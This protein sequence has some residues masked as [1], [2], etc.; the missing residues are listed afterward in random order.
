MPRRALIMSFPVAGLATALYVGCD[1]KGDGDESGATDGAS[2][3]DVDGDGD[4]DGV[5]DDDDDDTTTF[6][7]TDLDGGTDGGTA[8]SAW[9]Y[10][11]VEDI[12][13]APSGERPGGD[14]DSVQLY[15]GTEDLYATAAR[16]TPGTGQSPDHADCDALVGPKDLGNLTSG[17]GPDAVG[18]YNLGG[19]GKAEVDIGG[20][21]G[22]QEGDVLTAHECG[23]RAGD[24]AAEL[25]LSVSRDGDTWIEVCA[26]NAASG[27]SCTVPTLPD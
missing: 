26:G 9:L 10:A 23:S 4:T 16:C 14:I 11:L 17:C 15:T 2:D 8:D 19:G 27:L 25:R 3:A 5:F 24:D 1:T 21:R 18:V 12:T 20:E 22:V 7:D 6:D 13:P